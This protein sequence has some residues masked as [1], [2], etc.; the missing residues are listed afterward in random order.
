MFWQ[1]SSLTNYCPKFHLQSDDCSFCQDVAAASVRFHRMK[2]S[3][4]HLWPCSRSCFRW[5]C[6]QLNVQRMDWLKWLAEVPPP[7]PIQAAQLQLLILWHHSSG[8]RIM[9][10]GIIATLLLLLTF[11]SAR[12]LGQESWGHDEAVDIVFLKFKIMVVGLDLDLDYPGNFGTCSR[13]SILFC[14]DL[15]CFW[16]ATTVSKKRSKLSSGST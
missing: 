13:Y 3:S 11:A 15:F 7:S 12:V 9:H 1:D 14:K 5:S 10:Q 8:G 16:N 4:E 6:K 2:S